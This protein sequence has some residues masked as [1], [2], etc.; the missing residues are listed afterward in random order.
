MIGS[1][2]FQVYVALHR[3]PTED[4]GSACFISGGSG[5]R[6]YRFVPAT[7]SGSKNIPNRP[8]GRAG[9]GAIER[10]V[11]TVSTEALAGGRSATLARKVF[12]RGYLRSIDRSH[13]PIHRPTDRPILPSSLPPS[14]R[15]LTH[16][17]NLP[18]L[19]DGRPHSRHALSELSVIVC[20]LFFAIVRSAVRLLGVHVPSIVRRSD[21][22][23]PPVNL[24]LR[25]TSTPRRQSSVGRR[26]P[27]SAH[28][29][30][31]GGASAAACAPIR[32]AKGGCNLPAR[33]SRS[34]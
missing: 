21:R 3:S 1:G 9:G 2:T 28:D 20:A 14:V 17:R 26:E 32:G 27:R 34:P 4:P 7:W 12:V 19:T 29:S 11:A 22:Y 16:G 31:G 13:R 33:C 18:P 8:S 30:L 24:K 15:P 6:A 10:S 25:R 23:R 5:P